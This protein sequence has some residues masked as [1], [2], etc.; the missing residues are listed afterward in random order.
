MELLVFLASTNNE[1]DNCTVGIW[2]LGIFLEFSN[3]SRE[4]K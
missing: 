1:S 4:M 2:K 3:S